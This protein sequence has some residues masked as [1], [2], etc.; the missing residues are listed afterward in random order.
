MVSAY[1][2]V[3]L[4][5]GAGVDYVARLAVGRAAFT[6]RGHDA[7]VVAGTAI[8]VASVAIAGEPRWVLY[9]ALGWCTAWFAAT[10][11]MLSRLP[12]R[13][14]A[15]VGEPLPAFDVATTDGTR[16]S[17]D[18]LAAE[19]PFVLVLYRGKW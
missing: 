10:R 14:R 16:V 4:A 1:L 2:G 9:A 3:A 17:S 7:A 13:T 5:V 19:G 6:T 15:R 8:A 12:D 18:Q 11:A